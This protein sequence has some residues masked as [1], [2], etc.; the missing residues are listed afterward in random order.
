MTGHI[1][2]KMLSYI[3]VA[4]DSGTDRM[5]RRSC[6][7]PCP[8]RTPFYKEPTGTTV[9]GYFDVSVYTLPRVG[10]CRVTES[11]RSLEP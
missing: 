10:P 5:T 6:H 9:H 2:D 1:T 11:I 3:E 8:I 4:V 7:E